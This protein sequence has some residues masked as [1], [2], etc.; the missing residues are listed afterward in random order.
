MLLFCMLALIPSISV[1]ADN[2]DET[3]KYVNV[4]RIS[5][6]SRVETSVE[7]S[8]VAYPE[9]TDTAILVGF[10]G[11]ADALAGTLLATSKNAP[12]MISKKDKVDSVVMNELA[13]LGVKKVYILGGEFVVSKSVISQLANKNIKSERV[14]GDDRTS[15][16]VM[17]ARKTSAKGSKK[18]IIVDGWG[19]KNATIAPDALSMAPVSGVEG[20]PIL[21]ITRDKI[22]Q[23]TKDVLKDMNVE[24][25]II[26]GGTNAVPMNIENELKKNY[27]VKRIAGENR[28][29]TSVEVYDEFFG[30]EE[31]VFLSNGYDSV[32]ALLGGYMATKVNSPMLLTQRD[33]M[34]LSVESI[35]K[36]D[37]LLDVY[38]LGGEGVV[39]ENL[40]ENVMNTTMKIDRANASE[41]ISIE[42]PEPYAST[43]GQATHPDVYYNKDGWNG[44]KYWMAF[45]PYHNSDEENENPSVVYSDDGINFLELEGASNP[46]DSPEKGLQ[47]NNAHMSDTDMVIRDDGVMEVYYRYRDRGVGKG[48]TIFRKT[49]T[50][51][52]NWTEREVVMKGYTDSGKDILSP[53]IVLKD[54]MYQMWWVENTTV[55]TSKSETALEGDWTEKE[56]VS[57]GFDGK[58]MSPWHLD[59]YYENG[60]YYLV[61]NVN[62]SDIYSQR[63]LTIGKSVDGVDFTN[64]KTIMR[65]TESNWDNRDIYR[66]SIVKVGSIYKLYYSAMN[67]DKKWGIGLSESE[68]LTHWIGQ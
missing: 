5:G 21:L 12:I 23:E 50:D 41:P 29:E 55:Y 58:K 13:R 68:D 26:A 15:T 4:E 45:T 18:A 44:H 62:E 22:S 19:P 14:Y 36:K 65:P 17:L 46:I 64:I 31:A 59:M 53:A 49:T 9:G 11:M 38:L 25:I 32:D 30:I 60:V 43:Q 2:G 33:S 56:E 20:I 54:N 40:K 7:M 47:S 39:S 28:E 66:G 10:N 48:E 24:D 63:S 1:F 3:V 16:A 35:L 52:V 37:S 42:T 6:D 61:L 51:A 67:K 57:L 8:K 34:S 27:N